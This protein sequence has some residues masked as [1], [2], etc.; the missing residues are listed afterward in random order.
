MEPGPSENRSEGWWR[1]VEAALAN[2][3]RVIALVDPEM[4]RT[5]YRGAHLVIEKYA[6]LD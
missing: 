4:E 5:A 1:S 3:A 2:G 6:Q